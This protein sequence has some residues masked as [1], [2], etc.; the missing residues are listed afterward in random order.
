MVISDKM[1]EKL[2]KKGSVK[3]TSLTRFEIQIPVG[4][5]ESEFVSLFGDTLTITA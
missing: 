5:L 2:L 3:F 1:R 4:S